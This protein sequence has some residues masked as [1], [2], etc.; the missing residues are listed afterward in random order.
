MMFS[1]GV[2]SELSTCAP[3]NG[4]IVGILKRIAE[5]MFKGLADATAADEAAKR[6]FDVPVAAETKQD[7]AHTTKSVGMLRAEA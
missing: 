7:E 2:L 6:K 3:A 5:T 1:Q 4:Q